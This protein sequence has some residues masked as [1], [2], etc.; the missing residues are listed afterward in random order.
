MGDITIKVD[1]AEDSHNESAPTSDHS[2][3][4]EGAR[5]IGDTESSFN[6]SISTGNR[7][8][9]SKFNLKKNIQVPEFDPDIVEKGNRIIAAHPGLIG[10]GDFGLKVWR[11]PEKEDLGLW[12]HSPVMYYIEH[13]HDEAVKAL[14]AAPKN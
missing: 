4:T 2:Q 5:E 3:R 10:S 1:G 7:D 9:S 8:G 13:K 11:I 12:E 14:K 6:G